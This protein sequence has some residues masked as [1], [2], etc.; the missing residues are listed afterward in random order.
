M[1]KESIEIIRDALKPDRELMERTKSLAVCRKR[2]STHIPVLIAACLLVAICAS[3]TAMKIYNEDFTGKVPVSEATTQADEDKE[4]FY[5]DLVPSMSGS[6]EKMSRSGIYS[7]A[8]FSEIFLEGC[9]AVV[10]GEILSVREK[11][12]TV[13]YE[14][15]KFEKGGRLTSKTQTLIIEIRADKVWCGEIKEGGTVTVETEMY[16]MLT[17]AVGRKYVLPLCDEGEDIR[18]D[19]AGQ[20]YLSGDIKRESIYSIIYPFH[21]QIE[22]TEKGYL[23]TS[24]W[25]SLVT[26]ETK[27]VKVDISLSEDEESYIDDMKLNSKEVFTEQFLKLLTKVGLLI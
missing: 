15:D 11:E 20:K 3:F 2:R 7:V 27:D 17:P 9:V 18:L 5:S 1:N 4:L 12:Y 26:A 24:D 19:E 10:E 22:K 25:E 16:Y 23:F 6:A 14:F 8:P 21:A 13:I